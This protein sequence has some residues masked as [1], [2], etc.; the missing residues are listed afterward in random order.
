[1]EKNFSL[2]N[3]SNLCYGLFLSDIISLIGQTFQKA[4]DNNDYNNKG[5]F[6]SFS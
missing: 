4:I 1:L 2:E 6:P 5:F 3:F